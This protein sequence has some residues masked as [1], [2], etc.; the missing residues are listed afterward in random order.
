MILPKVSLRLKAKSLGL[1][2]GHDETSGGSVG[3]V[4]GV[5]GRNGTVW[6]NK[7]CL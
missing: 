3:K 1:I 5:G 4:G 2:L 6:F 7:G